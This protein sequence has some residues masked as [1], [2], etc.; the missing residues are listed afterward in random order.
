MLFIQ[1][2]HVEGAFT[3]MCLKLCT[4]HVLTLQLLLS[5]CTCCSKPLPMYLTS[6]SSQLLWTCR[7]CFRDLIQ[8]TEWTMDQVTKTS[9]LTGNQSRGKRPNQLMNLGLR[10]SG[11]NKEHTEKHLLILPVWEKW[12]VSRAHVSTFTTAYRSL[13]RICF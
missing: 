3:R 4:A 8:N 5:L 12:N 9:K 1:T 11:G 2:W 10:A 13:R 6:Y 7:Q